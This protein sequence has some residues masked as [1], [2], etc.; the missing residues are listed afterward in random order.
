MMEEVFEDVTLR[1][2]DC[3]NLFIFTSGEQEYFLS[4]MLSKPKRCPACRKKRR[5]R[6]VPDLNPWG[7]A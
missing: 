1:C 4:R 5:G 3:E 7:A 6:V 2:I